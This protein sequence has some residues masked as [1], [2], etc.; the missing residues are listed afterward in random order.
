M[1]M[2][3]YFRKI[4]DFK[5][6]ILAKNDFQSDFDDYIKNRRK[7][8]RRK[9]QKKQKKRKSKRNNKRSFFKRFSIRDLF[10]DNVIDYDGDI[11]IVERGEFKL[12][13][14]F[15]DLFFSDN[16]FLEVDDS[17][18]IRPKSSKKKKSDDKKSKKPK[19]VKTQKRSFIKNINPFKSSKSKEIIKNESDDE[20]VNL[21]SDHLEVNLDSNEEHVSVVE[22]EDENYFDVL[23]DKTSNILSEF[24]NI[25]SKSDEKNIVLD[26]FE[27]KSLKETYSILN[28]FVDSFSQ[29]DENDK[30]E[31]MNHDDFQYLL[32]LEDKIEKDIED[33]EKDIVLKEKNKEDIE[34]IEKDLDE[35]VSYLNKLIN[36]FRGFF[37]NNDDRMVI[38]VDVSEVD[39]DDKD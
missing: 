36:K 17:K 34:D 23:K 28:D 29:L 8:T 15:K 24:K 39:I 32:D 10:H 33:I 9:K 25:F 27:E 20:E 6:I 7:I 19:V 31:L 3:L 12:K 21:E 1:R 14:K 4:Y 5:V 2:I 18:N 22:V 30:K 11:K 26:N 35:K 13:K 37:R 16:N 38:N